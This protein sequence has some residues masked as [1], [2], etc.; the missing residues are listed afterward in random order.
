MR[1]EILTS[2]S[3]GEL[4]ACYAAR[5]TAQIE[6]ISV[7]AISLSRLR[8]NK[9]ASA[10]AQDIADLAYLAARESLR[11]RKIL[12]PNTANRMEGSASTQ[13]IVF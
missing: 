12:A 6:D 13:V 7:P 8:E 3:E 2:I 5:E 9:A 10:R 11:L 1:I 4:E